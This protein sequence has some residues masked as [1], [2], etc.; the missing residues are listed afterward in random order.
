VEHKIWLHPA[1]S[2]CRLP[3]DSD[4]NFVYDLDPDAVDRAGPPPAL[5]LSPPSPQ[6]LEGRGSTKEEAMRSRVV[7]GLMVAA[8]LLLLAGG[9]GLAR[10]PNP[11]VP[12]SDAGV[13]AYPDGSDQWKTDEV[14]TTDDMGQHTSIA[15]DQDTGEIWVSYYDAANADLKVSRFWGRNGNC[16]PGDAWVCQTVD[17]AGD[18]GKYN[19]IAV[20]QD[21]LMVAYYDASNR[22]L[23]MA[24][25]D[26]PIHWVWDIVTLDMPLD[27]S[28]SVGL[29]TSA[30][31]SDTGQEFI[32]YYLDNAIGVDDLK[33]AYH[34]YANGNCPGP[35]VSETWRCDT[36]FS[37]EG[38]GQYPSLQVV[39]GV[40]FDV[41]IAYY[42]ASSDDLWFATT[43]CGDT[44]NCGF[45]DGDM[46]CYPVTGTGADVGKYASLY[47]DSDNHFHIAYYDATHDTLKYAVQTGGMEGNCG[48]LGSARC[49]TIDGMQAD[50][51]PLGLSIAEDANRYPVIA[52]QSID[53]DL[54]WARPIAALGLPAGS[55]NCGP[56]DPLFL[57]WYC[58]KVDPAGT[59][60]Y[61]RN[62][63]F[64]SIAMRP[65]GF[66]IVA[67]YRLYVDHAD[68]N[69]VVSRHRPNQ[70][71]LPLVVRNQQ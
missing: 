10:E 50:Y 55:G 34:T 56:E 12:S 9:V 28:R 63:D 49:D 37:G 1:G 40:N 27:S 45:W 21:K 62:G 3:P 65:H 38:V 39:G 36:I 71:H 14:D 54:N 64:A 66:A 17:S 46:A 6:E 20:W 42:N 25:S 61:T 4:R 70:V 13:N 29:Y 52:Y 53:G 59:W 23:K 18:V 67:F 43:L 11:N 2:F 69:L 8:M 58:E 33:V 5:V 24:M 19:S 7:P 44:C 31:F 57:T 68:G 30:Q 41:H 22:K 47:V 48:V 26:D 32:A 60:V 51:H 16:G 35:D 15:I